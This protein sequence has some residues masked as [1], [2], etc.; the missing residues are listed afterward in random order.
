MSLTITISDDLSIV[1]GYPYV[2]GNGAIPVIV[3][4]TNNSPSDSVQLRQIYLTEQSSALG[5]GAALSLGMPVFKSINTSNSTANNVIP[6]LGT[7]EYGALYIPQI[8]AVGAPLDPTAT[9]SSTL[10]KNRYT[11]ILV[12]IAQV[13]GSTEMYIG[14]PAQF[15]VYP[16]PTIGYSLSTPV[17]VWS[18]SDNRRPSGNYDFDFAVGVSETL[19]NGQVLQVPPDQLYFSSTQPSIC[20]VVQTG[21]YGATTGEDSQTIGGG[22]AVTVVSANPALP[23]VIQVR[24]WSAV[25]PIIG[26]IKVYVVPTLPVSLEITPNLVSLV[27][28]LSLTSTNRINFKAYINNSDGSRI[29]ITNSTDTTWLLN[30]TDGSGSWAYFLPLATL[31]RGRLYIVNDNNELNSYSP[32]TGVVTAT[33]NYNGI[34]TSGIANIFVT[35]SV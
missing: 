16:S 19:L 17:S 22:G 6:P 25:D 30:G 23:A 29:D 27:S 10:G 9:V 13:Y 11:L 20:T 18:L 21:N 34:S 5:T 2:Q 35:I 12:A 31:N 3:N 24:R 15:F 1:D 32:T 33:Y 4:V 8:N 26:S 28:N 7:Q 14:D